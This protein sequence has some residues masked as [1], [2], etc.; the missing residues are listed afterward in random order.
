VLHDFA[1][2]RESLKSVTELGAFRDLGGSLITADGDGRPVE[3]VEISAAAFR[4]ARVRPLLGRT[5]VA[6]DERPDAPPVVV[7]GHGVWQ[8][9]FAGDSGAVG[10]TV[11][12]GDTYATVVGVMPAGFAFPVSHELWAPLRLN[13][14]D[15]PRGVGPELTVFGR[16]APGVTLDEAQAELETLGRRAS[17][18]FPETHRHLRPRVAPYATVFLTL[19]AEELRW[20]LAVNVF[21]VMLLVLACSNVAL[22]MFARAATR[23]GELTVR[24]ALGAGRGRIVAQL[25]AEALVLG[26][27]ASAVGLAAAGFG[28]RWGLGFLTLNLG[29]LPF[30]YTDRLSPATL[31]YAAGL[32]AL[33]AAVAGVVPALKVTR[34]LGARLRQAS[35]G[36]GGLQFG[37]VWTAVIVV[38]VAV[39]VTFPMS[40][41]VLQRE[42][43]QTRSYDVGFAAGEYLSARVEMDPRATPGAPPESALAAHRARFGAALETLR[44]RVA[45]EPGVTGVT[46]VDVLPRMYHPPSH[47]ELDEGEAAPSVAR[48][49]TYYVSTASVDPSYFDVLDRPVVAGRA[50]RAADLGPEGRAVI[51]DQAFV[52][53]VLRGRNPIGRRLRFVPPAGAEHGGAAA[54]A[55]PWYEIVGVA[56]SLGMAYRHG[57]AA[58]LYRPA[59]LGSGGRINLAV[60]V[61]GDPAALAP[62]VR[63]IATAVDPTLRLSGI[64]PLDGIMNP[65]LWALSRVL[66]VTV[67]LSGVALLLSLAG[68]YA[69]LSFTVARRTRE[70]GVRV[71]LG[72]SRRRVVAAIFR[73]PVAQVG[74]GVAAGGALIA[75]VASALPGAGLG[76]RQLALLAA[77]A[78]FMLGVCLLACVV[79]TRRALRV[80]P[81][82][83]LRADG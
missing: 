70:I 66:S 57:R 43:T 21:M 22:L 71:A 56:R 46:F 45:A 61:R 5:L 55:A 75:A 10:R 40:T 12:I 28:L 11:R 39:T 60:H 54:A 23:E 3:A 37:G 9:R 52:E 62:R 1:A 74:L 78:L 67:V 51:V 72:A 83:A 73:R 17:A 76:P 33:G 4:L 82:E 63:A 29:R 64:Q 31:L 77:Y 36:G 69:V 25:F 48:Q 47:I 19:S 59:A 6:G 14:V 81:T 26:G 41:F 68:I 30:W 16:L 80:E 38:Q 32:T 24:T 65:G 13:A 27:L 49:R 53:D 18:E 20:L 7:I 42:L 50:F 8:A 35:A 2:W 15:Y 34:G 44:Q 79:P 58:G